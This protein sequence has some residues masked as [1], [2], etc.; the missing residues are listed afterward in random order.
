M[1]GI[2]NEGF[3]GW[4]RRRFLPVLSRLFKILVTL[5]KILK[6]VLARIMKV[7]CHL[8]KN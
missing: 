8:I 7:V 2:S 1:R 5:W 4:A 6:R 3:P